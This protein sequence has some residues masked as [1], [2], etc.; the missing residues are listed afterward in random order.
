MRKFLIGALTVLVVGGAYGAAFYYDSPR[1]AGSSTLS[2]G[3]YWF[4]VDSTDTY[5][6]DTVY[7]DTVAVDTLAKWMNLSLQ[8]MGYT[9]CD[10][11]NAACTVIVKT[12]T[13]YN[14]QFPI[15]L[16]TDTITMDSTT[17]ATVVYKNCDSIAANQLWFETVVADSFISNHA[18]SS[19][20]D[21]IRLQLQYKVASKAYMDY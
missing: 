7:S 6:V 15:T 4:A 20:L 10:S 16:S 5:M 11:C 19:D 12:K 18:A 2:G 14:G 8:L 9:L 3:Q 17:S 21:S 1:F 13:T